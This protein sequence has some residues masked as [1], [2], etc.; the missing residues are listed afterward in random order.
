MIL[1]QYQGNYL[2]ILVNQIEISLAQTYF[3]ALFDLQV[4][5]FC[6]HLFI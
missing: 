1:F 4:F 3:L 6:N 2:I 5:I